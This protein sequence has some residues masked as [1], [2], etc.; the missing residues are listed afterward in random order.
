MLA[1]G[2]GFIQPTRA[3]R[4]PGDPGIDWGKVMNGYNYVDAMN[5]TGAFAGLQTKTT[6]ASRYG[7]PLSFQ[8]ARTIRVA[9][10]FTF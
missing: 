4:F 8:N 6:L 3:S 5:G 7:L 1:G 10:R 9:V 2:T